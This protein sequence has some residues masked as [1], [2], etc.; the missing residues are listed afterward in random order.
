MRGRVTSG[1]AGVL[2][3]ADQGFQRSASA[4]R[5]LGLT[6]TIIR[7]CAIRMRQSPRAAAA[8]LCTA[9]M[10]A[11]RSWPCFQKW[12]VAAAWRSHA[13]ESVD[14]A[15][16]VSIQRNCGHQLFRNS[17]IQS[18]KMPTRLTSLAKELTGSSFAGRGFVSL[19]RILFGGFH[20][21]SATRAKTGRIGKR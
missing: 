6:T 4:P 21:L 19:E 5:P 7:P 14:A 13:D 3:A 17:K 9:C 18:Y 15:H 20:A 16:R 2:G 11:C 10:Q 1:L 8:S 12:P